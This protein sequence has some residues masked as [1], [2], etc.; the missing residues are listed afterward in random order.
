MDNNIC[1]ILIVSFILFLLL[2][3]SGIKELLI[4]LGGA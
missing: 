1:K 3:L 4:F 2:M